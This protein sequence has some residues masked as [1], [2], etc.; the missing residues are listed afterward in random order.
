MKKERILVVEDDC[1][2]AAKIEHQ[3]LKLGYSIAGMVS[4]GEEAVEL[5]ERVKPDLVLMDIGLEGDLDGV[6]VATIVRRKSAVPIVFLTANSDASTINRARFT[7]AHGF[8]HKPFHE[9]ELHSVLQ[10][11]LHKAWMEA[12]VREE[13][14]WLRTTLRCVGDAVIAA[15]AMGEVKF[16]NLAAERLTGWAEPDAMGR[17]LS[18]V[19]RA[20]EVGTR[21]PV[22]CAVTRAIKED[23]QPGLR[24]ARLL[25]SRAGTETLVEENAASIENDAGCL[26]GVVLVFHPA[27]E[28]ANVV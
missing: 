17:D 26:T 25:V 10:I 20:L 7:E 22:E 21:S 27:K 16:V 19:Y 2:T 24:S 11:A 18:E 5:A 12:S 9:Q 14:Q 6:E 3:L 4:S 8:L 28:D 23:F 1:V 13:Q 15:N